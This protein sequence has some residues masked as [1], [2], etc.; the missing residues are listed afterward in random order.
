MTRRGGKAKTG[1]AT[2]GGLVVVVVFFVFVSPSGMEGRGCVGVVAREA[3]SM[4]AGGEVSTFRGAGVGVFHASPAGGA[5]SSSGRC[6]VGGGGRGGGGGGRSG[7]GGGGGGEGSELLP[8]A[9][10]GRGEDTMLHQEIGQ[11]RAG[12]ARV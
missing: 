3:S 6:P 4:E 11:L 7:G 10:A 1:D 9:G 12:N 8:A 2:A 5:G